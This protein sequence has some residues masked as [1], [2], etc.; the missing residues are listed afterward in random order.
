MV[1]LF[2]LQGNIIYIILVLRSCNIKPLQNFLFRCVS[3]FIPW[4][5]LKLSVLVRAAP[6]YKNVQ[7]FF[8]CDVQSLNQKSFLKRL[9]PLWRVILV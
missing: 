9:S 8:T 4:S 3:H 2:R 1:F 7:A 5:G 6:L